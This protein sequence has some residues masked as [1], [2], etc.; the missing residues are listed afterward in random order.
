MTRSVRPP[1]PRLT[2]LLPPSPPPAPSRLYLVF[3]SVISFW[4]QTLRVASLS[5]GA[6]GSPAPGRAR[7]AASCLN[8]GM[9]LSCFTTT[10]MPCLNRSTVEAHPPTIFLF[11]IEGLT[12]QALRGGLCWSATADDHRHQCDPTSGT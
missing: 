1:A 7:G 2:H 12:P 11:Q 9:Q 10:Q 5:W 8:K 3:T 6:M 4:E